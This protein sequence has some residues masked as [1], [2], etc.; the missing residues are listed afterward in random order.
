MKLKQDTLIAA[1]VALIVGII[2]GAAGGGALQGTAVDENENEGENI[3]VDPTRF[4]LVKYEDA[5]NYLSQQAD[6]NPDLAD[7]L[8]D[9]SDLASVTDLSQFVGRE[10]AVNTILVSLQSSLITQGGDE[11]FALTTCL[12]VDSGSDPYATSGAGVYV[13]IEVSDNVELPN[14][15]TGNALEAP[16]QDNLTWSSTCIKGADA[17]K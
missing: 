5:Q 12:G 11:P 14:E 4:Y 1:V 7:S 3:E 8:T 15:L 16:K 6:D 17:N 13:Y 2:I 9:L 10:A